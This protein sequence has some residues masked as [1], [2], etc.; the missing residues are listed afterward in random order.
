MNDVLN[1][2]S[3][4]YKLNAGIILHPSIDSINKYQLHWFYDDEYNQYWISK[5]DMTDIST[6][7]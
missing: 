1:R 2:R 4:L 3:Y 7:V 6:N 5:L